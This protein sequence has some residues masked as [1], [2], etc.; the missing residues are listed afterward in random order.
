MCNL[1]LEETLLAKH[2]H[3]YFLSLI[4]VT[5][6]AYHTNNGHF[7]DKGFKDDCATSDQSIMFCGVG[8]QSQN[9]I[10]GHK[11]EKLTLGAWTLHLHAKKNA[12]RIHLDNFMIICPEMRWR[13]IEYS[14]PSS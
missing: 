10:A 7:A 6:K 2:A 9:G 4:R 5:A 14:C 3:E 11:I 8:N 13:Q 1:S 12:S